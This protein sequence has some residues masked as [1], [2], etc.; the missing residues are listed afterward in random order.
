MKKI[1]SAM[2]IL[3][4]HVI[5]HAQSWTVGS[6]IPTPIRAGN[7]AAYT[8]NGEGFLFVISGRDNNEIITTKHQRYQISTN[9]WTEMAPHPTGILGAS[10][11]ILKDSIYVIGGLLTTPGNATRLVHKYSI[12]EN[13]WSL[14]TNYPINTVDTDAV[15][16]QDSLIY[17]AAGYSNR[18]RIYNA[19]T[20]QWRVA[21]SMTPTNQS[22][23][24]GALTVKNDTLVYMCGTDNFLSPNYYNT[25]RIG[26]INQNDRSQI[27]WTEGAPF[28]GATRTFFDAHPWK[29]G[30]I[31]TG[32]STD[33]TFETHSDETY[34]YNVGLNIW[35][36]LPSKPTPWLTGNSGS[37][38]ID[39]EWKLI[40]AGGYA[41]NY[42]SQT[43]LFSEQEI[44]GISDFNN[45]NCSLKH[46]KFI[47]N[48]S[49]ELR[50][51]SQS[52]SVVNIAI[53]DIH[54]RL[55]EKFNAIYPVSGFQ[56]VN[57]GGSKLSPGIYFCTLSQENDTVTKKIIVNR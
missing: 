52:N 4:S 11:A 43:E 24:W 31:M 13:T 33:N 22:I 34:H 39:E 36:Q 23:S 32:G 25:V 26:V 16:Y 17:V 5:L 35:K 28:P 47:S 53:H 41:G 29:D 30:I 8:K 15:A 45:Q 38:L 44:L 18:V 20:N 46:F 50:F 6:D 56:N 55:V 49:N 54:G 37:I 1:T 12:N 14:A 9:T 21:T 57:L 7:T 40:C 27:T 10:T 2:L 42:L 3:V 19:R 48:D 51:C